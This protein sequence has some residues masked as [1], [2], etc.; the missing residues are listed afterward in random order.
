MAT[1][2]KNTTVIPTS[3]MSEQ[4]IY[5][6][7]HS[8]VAQILDLMMFDYREHANLI[9]TFIFNYICL[10]TL[11]SKKSPITKSLIVFYLFINVT[12]FLY[13]FVYFIIRQNLGDIVTVQIET[14]VILFFDKLSHTTSDHFTIVFA[15]NR[16][17]A[18][19]YPFQHKQVS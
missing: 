17:T 4:D 11:Q 14:G 1:T 7:E 18:L 9:L 3:T 13:H 16:L 10:K 8:I 5:F 2:P 15:V 12:S 6:A 19:L